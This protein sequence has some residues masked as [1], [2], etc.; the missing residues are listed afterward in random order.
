LPPAFARIGPVGSSFFPPGLKNT[1]LISA[2]LPLFTRRT[3]LFN[4]SVFFSSSL[5]QFVP[6]VPFCDRGLSPFRGGQKPFWRLLAS[7]FSGFL[8]PVKFSC[9][10]LVRSL[11]IDLNLRDFSYLAP[12]SSILGEV[13]L[14]VSVVSVFALDSHLPFPS[15][16]ER[17]RLC[18]FQQSL[19]CRRFEVA[20]DFSP[21]GPPL[22]FPSRA[23]A[24]GMSPFG[25]RFRSVR[26]FVFAPRLPQTGPPLF[27]SVLVF[28]SIWLVPVRALRFGRRSSFVRPYFSRL[29]PTC[30][31]FPRP[32]SPSTRPRSGLF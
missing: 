31:I 30:F 21:L 8:L 10:R 7:F 2:F 14:D 22:F 19:V 16:W 29:S 11:L 23:C 17:G 15:V 32:T 5:C 9:A 1:R 26:C 25:R 24:L 28:R 27:S 13:S 6:A 20:E 18:I 3:H 4:G 12:R